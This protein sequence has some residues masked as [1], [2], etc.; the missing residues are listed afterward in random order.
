MSESE[1]LFS[2]ARIGVYPGRKYTPPT[3][4]QKRKDYD[5]S[6]LENKVF[7]T[8]KQP[9]ITPHF[10]D[11][12][13][14]L[15]QGLT[16][17]GA[18]S[19]QSKST[20]AANILAG[21]IQYKPDT[22]AYVISNEEKVD[23]I[24]HRTACVLL[25]ES[26]FAFHGGSLN[27]KSRKAVE[28]K[29]IELLDRITIV[30]DPSWTTTSLEDVKSI[31]ESAMNNGANMVLIDYFQT[32]NHS[33]DHP[34][35]EIFQ[36]L[37]RMGIFLREYGR[38]SPVPIVVFCQLDPTSVATEFQRRVQNDKQ[39][40]NDAFN[41]V[42]IKPNFSTSVTEFIVH[43]QRFGECMSRTVNMKFI[44]GRYELEAGSPI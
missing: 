31:C 15:S 34:T 40:F 22:L 17:I 4:E 1:K 20:T 10:A 13:F 9:F 3:I 37:K 44:K 19:G 36:V 14:F 27:D 12:D 35:L 39:I 6:C 33:K 2:N 23:T 5:K 28:D 25:K 41:V 16:L 18:C 26:F 7:Q 21:F 8:N 32:I 30:E 11:G 42:E 29:A 24:L 38:K 43:K